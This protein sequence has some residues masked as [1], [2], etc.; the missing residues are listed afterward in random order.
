MLYNSTFG[1]IF[2][3]KA[4]SA[5]LKAQRGIGSEGFKDGMKETLKPLLPIPSMLLDQQKL[6]F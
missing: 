4:I 1:E 5:D 6:P 2:A 3:K